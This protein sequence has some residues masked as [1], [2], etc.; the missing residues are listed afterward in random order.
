[1]TL[2]V[3][4]RLIISAAAHLLRIENIASPEIITSLRN[5]RKYDSEQKYVRKYGACY[6]MQTRGGKYC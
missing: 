3:F 5:G 6:K 4:I 2:R 1:M